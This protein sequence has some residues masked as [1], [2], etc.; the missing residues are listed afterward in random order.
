M[1][2]LLVKGDSGWLNIRLKTVR[3]N[4]RQ[5]NLNA[6]NVSL[7]LLN[8]SASESVIDDSVAADDVVFLKSLIVSDENME[9]FWE[10]LNFTRSYR[11][12]ML[13]DKNIHLKEQFP[14]FFTHPE[15][16]KKFL[17]YFAYLKKPAYNVKKF[18]Q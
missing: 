13:L 1:Q 12:K 4:L 7:N 10:K 15:M 9:T 11:Q 6:A 17:I 2:D 5:L 18:L 16:V 14:Y 8:Q 3:E